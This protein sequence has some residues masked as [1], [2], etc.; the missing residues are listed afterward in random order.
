MSRKAITANR[1]ID[2]RVV[3]L[4]DAGAWSHRFD[5]AALHAGDVVEARLAALAAAPLGAQVVGAYAVAVDGDG[6]RPTPHGAR[7]RIRTRGP[8]VRPDLGVQAGNG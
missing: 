2:G 5:D 4:T 8:S 6:L 7:E 3:F 1:L